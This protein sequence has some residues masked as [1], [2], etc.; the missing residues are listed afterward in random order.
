VAAAAGA[1]GFVAHD[2][3]SVGVSSRPSVRIVEPTP[4][5]SD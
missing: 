3:F 4:D 5:R 2:R 1:F